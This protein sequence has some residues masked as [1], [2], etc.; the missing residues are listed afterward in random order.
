MQV[1]LVSPGPGHSNFSA[2]KQAPLLPDLFN[3]TRAQH[4]LRPK[5]QDRFQR[6]AA[7]MYDEHLL[8]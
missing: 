6:P 7:F 1:V 8:N 5:R 2:R 4:Y 3:F